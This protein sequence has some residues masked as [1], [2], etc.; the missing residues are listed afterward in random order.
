[1]GEND[2]SSYSDDI[3]LKINYDYETTRTIDTGQQEHTFQ[4]Y[5][6]PARYIS[7]HLY[8]SPIPRD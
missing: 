5:G 3:D 6:L 2:E 7:C 8:T 4:L 1:M